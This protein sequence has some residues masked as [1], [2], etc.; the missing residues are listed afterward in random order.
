MDAYDHK[1]SKMQVL[2]V[3]LGLQKWYLLA[4]PLG[5]IQIA[6][7]CSAASTVLRARLMFTEQVRRQQT[8]IFDGRELESCEMLVGK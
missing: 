5:A 7:W 3:V 8:L 4:V 1:A 6:G 2:Q